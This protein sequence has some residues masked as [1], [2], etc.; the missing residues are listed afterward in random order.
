MKDVRGSEWE[1]CTGM[2]RVDAKVF[3]VVV[4]P[5]PPFMFVRFL[6]LCTRPKYYRSVCLKFC[7]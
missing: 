2:R 5:V 7:T 1:K 3:V 6:A 4:V